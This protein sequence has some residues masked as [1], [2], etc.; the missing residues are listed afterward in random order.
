MRRSNPFWIIA[1][2]LLL[3]GVFFAQVSPSLAELVSKLNASPYDNA[4]REQVIKLAL[5][6]KPAP[7]I[8][9]MAREHFVE[10]TTLAKLSK[11]VSGQKLAVESFRKALAAAPWWGD[12]YYN[13]AI[14]QELSGQFSEAQ[15]SLKFYIMTMPGEKEARDA[16]D[17]I[18]ALNAKKKLAEAEANA[19]A[20]DDLA[21]QAAEIRRK[22]AEEVAF[23]KG[24]WRW[25]ESNTEVVGELDTAG[26]VRFYYLSSGNRYLFLRGYL[27]PGSTQYNWTLSSGGCGERLLTVT[28]SSDRRRLDYVIPECY[29][30][31]GGRSP[32]F[33]VNRISQ[34]IHRR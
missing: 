7:V 11:D 3:F 27:Q 10:G 4:V 31:G 23:W 17:K 18:Y 13:L 24:P 5:E 8:S 32:Y 14:A 30:P 6:T 26:A 16:Q 34:T 22:Q 19:K 25:N 15:N 28:V 2:H 21:K 1:G 9:E 29:Y 33:T 12:A 20:L